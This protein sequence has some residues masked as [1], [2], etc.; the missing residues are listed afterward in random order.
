[1]IWGRNLTIHNQSLARAFTRLNEF[2]RDSAE[3]AIIFAPDAA[4]TL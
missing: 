4:S 1:M 2:Y 3:N